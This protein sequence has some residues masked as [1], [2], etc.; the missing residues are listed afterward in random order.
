MRQFV[1][2]LAVCVLAGCSRCRS[3]P[4]HARNAEKR[5]TV[6]NEPYEHFEL[7]VETT[8]GG[9]SVFVFRFPDAVGQAPRI[10]SIS[11]GKT[12]MKGAF[13]AFS[14]YSLE[15]PLMTGFWPVGMVPDNYRAADG[16]HENTLSPGDYEVQISTVQRGPVMLRLHV[17]SAGTV[18]VLPW[19]E[20]RLP[21]S[22]KL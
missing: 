7:K 9:T 15:G 1:L 10:S 16:C 20:Q 21:W 14:A 12:G 22:S 11:I 4:D 6:R 17:T 2:F 18:Q 13:C 19:E 8:E 3:E 5:V